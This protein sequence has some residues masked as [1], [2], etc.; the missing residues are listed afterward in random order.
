MAE[1]PNVFVVGDAAVYKGP[2][3]AARQGYIAE[4]MGRNAAHNIVQIEK[5]TT[6]FKGCQG[7]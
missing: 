7:I 3:W 5:C 1:F 6:N 4:I 2:D